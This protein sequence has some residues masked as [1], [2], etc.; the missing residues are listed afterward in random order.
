MASIASV[1]DATSR[2]LKQRTIQ[3]KRQAVEAS[4]L[5]KQPFRLHCSIRY[6]RYILFK[7]SSGT[8]ALCL[9]RLAPSSANLSPFW[10]SPRVG[11]GALN[12]IP[13][14]K[15]YNNTLPCHQ[16]RA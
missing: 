2:F 10:L 16:T 1:L 6:I 4:V 11:G 5:V 15:G 7:L 13:N 14:M 9:Q 12:G 8:T 3:P